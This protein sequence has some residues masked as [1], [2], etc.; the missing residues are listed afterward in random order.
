[1][2]K[3]W[4][5]DELAEVCCPVCHRQ[6]KRRMYEQKEKVPIC[7]KCHQVSNML[8]SN[9]CVTAKQVRTNKIVGRKKG[10]YN[11]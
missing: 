6:L 8:C 2:K 4:K 5:F 10:R 9:P 1:M 11:P 7:F 3:L